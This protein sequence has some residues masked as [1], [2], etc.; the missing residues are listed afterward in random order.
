M[1]GINAFPLVALVA[2]F[3]ST[4]HA[5]TCEGVF[6]CLEAGGALARTENLYA[7]RSDFCGTRKCS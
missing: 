1:F 2:A 3:T 7:A 4:A 5:A 6:T